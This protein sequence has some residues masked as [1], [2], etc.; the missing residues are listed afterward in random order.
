MGRGQADGVVVVE[1][2][3]WATHPARQVFKQPLLDEIKVFPVHLAN[4]SRLGQ[5]V[6]GIVKGVSER[7]D[8]LLATE[9]F[10]GGL[11]GCVHSLKGC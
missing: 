6:H 8:F 4:A 3:G 10:I 11:H 1:V 2:Q 5:P 7:A 9:Q